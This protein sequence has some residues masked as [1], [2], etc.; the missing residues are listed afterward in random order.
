MM[1]T[2]S[3]PLSAVRGTVE[4]QGEGRIV[5]ALPGTDYRLYLAVAGP[6]EPSPTGSI[7]GRIRARARRVDK[8]HGG[9][10]GRYIEPVYGRPRRVQ[11]RVI[12]VD[13]ASNTITVLAACPV[14][15]QLTS[16][17]QRAEQFTDGDF[18]TFDVEPGAGFTPAGSNP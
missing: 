3:A 9:R 11:G 7:Q 8:T 4:E 5:L 12:A 6:V 1:E 10:G 13:A 17:G 15:C 16:P 18:V 2:A 14:D